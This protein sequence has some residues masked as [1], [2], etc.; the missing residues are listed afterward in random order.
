ML[1]RQKLRM[2]RAL[3]G[4]LQLYRERMNRLSRGL[5]SPEMLMIL[6]R[7]DSVK[8]LAGRM[9]IALER[10]T[11]ASRG[12]LQL[13]TRALNGLNPDGVLSRGYAWVESDG[14][15]ITDVQGVK[16][17]QDVT[18]TLSGGVLDARVSRVRQGEMRSGS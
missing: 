10:R 15:I 1:S 14:K 11:V 9:D 17:G 3:G 13:L 6:P 7:R 5:R 16:P 12:R 18:I 2:I 4:R 8:R